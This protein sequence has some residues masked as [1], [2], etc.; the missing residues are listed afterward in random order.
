MIFMRLEDIQT[1]A[2]DELQKFPFSDYAASD[3]RL[4][5]LRHDVEADVREDQVP[6]V[7][8][9]FSLLV[10]LHRGNP[11]CLLPY[12]RGVGVVAPLHAPADIGLVTLAGRPGH[13]LVLIKD[14][15]VNGHVVVLVPHGED[16]VVEDDVARVDLITEILDDVF[17]HGPQGEGENRKVL[18]LLQHLPIPV[19]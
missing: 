6:H 2:V 11:E 1:V 15:L 18:R 19:I 4:H 5:V 9:E 7:L 17:A 13:Q 10:D 8:P 3:L 12:L 14:G 16:I